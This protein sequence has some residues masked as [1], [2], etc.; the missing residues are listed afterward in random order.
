M[1]FSLF[2]PGTRK[3]NPFW[4]AI[5]TVDERRI[6]RSSKTTS[7][8]E[9]RKFAEG[10]EREMIQKRL[11][12]PGDIVT[13]AEAARLYAAFR[14]LDLQNPQSHHGN[15]RTEAKAINRLIGELG[16]RDIAEMGQTDLVATAN[17][18]YAGKPAMIRKGK[19]VRTA[20]PHSQATKN[21]W[22]VKPGAAILHYAAEQKLCGWERIKKFKEKRPPTRAVAVDT[23]AELVTAAPQG[24]KRLLLVWLF[25]QGTRITDTLQVGWDENINLQRQTVRMHIGKDDDW[26]EFPL[27]PEVF[28]MLAEI[29]EAKRTG[30]LFPWRTRS[31]VYRWLRPLTRRLGIVFTPHMGRHSVGTWMNE[32]RAG[33]RTI[34]AALHHRDPA[35]SI[36]YQAAD[37]EIVRAATSRF[38]RIT[39][40]GRAAS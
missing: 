2:A 12:R 34:M 27:H 25:R 7:K 28:E 37:V 39:D 31:G 36:R 21:R 35:S 11:P 22:V 15:A 5:V 30:R 24:R 40:K 29:P 6:E 4:I 26:T 23:A 9:A 18:F 33:L 38:A 10:L 13:F 14:G 19:L 3:N 32:E 1:P 16:K 8:I 20:G 17:K